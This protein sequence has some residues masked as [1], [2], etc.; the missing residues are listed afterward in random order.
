VFWFPIVVLQ[1]KIVIVETWLSTVY[2]YRYCLI[3]P[4][5]MGTS[6]ITVWFHCNLIIKLIRE[7]ESSMICMSMFDW[8]NNSWIVFNVLMLNRVETSDYVFIWKLLNIKWVK[9]E[10]SELSCKLFWKAY[11]FEFVDTMLSI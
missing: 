1:F 4:S 9:W 3:T 6:F 10:E 7:M 11:F 8:G 2:I 5:N